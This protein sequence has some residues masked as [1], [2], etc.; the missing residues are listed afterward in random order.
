MS[1]AGSGRGYEEGQRYS[2]RCVLA[3]GGLGRRAL[4]PEER[5][6]HQTLSGRAGADATSAVFLRSA[7]S[8]FLTSFLCFALHPH[9]SVREPR[10][11]GWAFRSSRSLSRGC[12]VFAQ[13]GWGLSP[14]LRCWSGTPNSVRM[15]HPWQACCSEPPE[16]PRL[17]ELTAC[18]PVIPCAPKTG[19]GRV[20]AQ[21]GTRRSRRLTAATRPV[22]GAAGPKLS[23]DF[24]HLR[25]CRHCG[26][27][28]RGSVAGS[29]EGRDPGSTS[30]RF[31][32]ALGPSCSVPVAPVSSPAPP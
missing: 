8:V 15:G 1:L 32:A 19:A 11:P 14:A 13:P 22:S 21:H 24:L 2:A 10:N 23:G 3:I 17:P 6:P 9:V 30:R 12:A 27:R 28:V 4:G 18:A 20:L 7:S 31:W 5:A 29:S 16:T 25:L 26:C